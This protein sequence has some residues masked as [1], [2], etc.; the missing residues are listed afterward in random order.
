MRLIIGYEVGTSPKS[1]L[2]F[3]LGNRGLINSAV[4]ASAATGLS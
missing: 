1:I 2:L 4:A 3:L